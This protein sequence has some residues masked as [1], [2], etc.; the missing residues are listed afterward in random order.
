LAAARHRRDFETEAVAGGG[1]GAS[2]SP[3]RQEPDSHC[4]INDAG[5]EM[6]QAAMTQHRAD[7]QETDEPVTLHRTIQ[8]MLGEK[9]RAHYRAPKKLSHELFVLMMQ[10]KEQ[11][12]QQAATAARKTKM[13]QN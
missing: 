13:A 9:L 10:I 2:P 1:R 7:S 4:S 5:L 8:M 11:E 3:D 6:R 12:R